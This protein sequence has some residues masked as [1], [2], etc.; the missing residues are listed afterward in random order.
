[1]N[2]LSQVYTGFI[3][4]LLLMLAGF[5]SPATALQSDLESEARTMLEQRDAQI[6]ELLGP[7]GTEHTE[8]QRQE[9][10]DIINEV[11]DYKAM[12]KHALQ[13]AWDD[14]SEEQQSEFVDVFARVIRDQSLNSL[15]IYR[16]DVIYESF[17]VDGNIVTARTVATLENVRTPV[18]YEME[19]RSDGWFV[20]DMSVDNVSTAESYRRSFQRIISR[21][22][23]DALLDNLKRRAGLI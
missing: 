18:T 2:S 5:P 12:A 10:M 7:K 23:Y 14:L 21:R 19:K 13:S 20:T 4:I 9:L 3:V 16:A 1:M 6:K 17:E 15:D 8:E 11:I 22:G